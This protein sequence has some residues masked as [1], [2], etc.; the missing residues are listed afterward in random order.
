MA[1]AVAA[2]TVRHLGLSEVAP[3]TLRRACAVHPITALQ[4]EW[5]LWSRD[6]ED[7]V[8]PT[9]RQLGVGIVAFSPLGRGF[10][11]GNVR[12]ADDLAADDARRQQPRFTGHNLARNLDLV[13]RVR[14]LADERG[15]TAAQLALAW[16]HARGGDVVPI[17]GTKRRRYLEENVAA[18]HIRLTADELARIEQAAP[19][20]AVAGDRYADMRFVE[21]RTPEQP[22][23]P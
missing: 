20:E 17:P 7:E 23:R 13:S 10:L 6:I 21:G 18:A 5:S 1:E 14:E 15:C 19:R 4:S 9:C 8:V 12:S 22:S 11:T 2:G 3:D 16:V